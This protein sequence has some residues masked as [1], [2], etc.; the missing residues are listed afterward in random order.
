MAVDARPE[1]PTEPLQ[2]GQ[3]IVRPQDGT[4]LAAGHVLVLSVREFSLLVA[5]IRREGIVV[6]RE[7]LF[8]TVWGGELRPRD[9]S[10]DVYVHKLRVKLEQA[11]P[12][13]TYIHTHTGFGYRL[14]PEL[15]RPDHKSDTGR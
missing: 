7:D 12:G 8:R 14:Q 6:A 2:S 13:W 10:V 5:L 9:R 15:S 11:L 1:N 3:L 4:V